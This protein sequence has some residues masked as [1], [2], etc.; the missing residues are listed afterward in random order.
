MLSIRSIFLLAAVLGAASPFMIN[1]GPD[2]PRV[3]YAWFY[4]LPGVVSNWL[5]PDSDIGFM[6]LTMAVYMAQY[7]AVFIFV[8]A[9]APLTR[10]FI[11]PHKHRIGLAGRQ[12]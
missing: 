10:D 1:V 3:L 11:R 5:W 12:D 9:V 6:A 8:A 7:F 2:T 4:W